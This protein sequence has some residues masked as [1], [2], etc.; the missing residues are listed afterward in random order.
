[1]NILFLIGNGFDLNLDM[2]TKYSDFYKHYKLIQ[3]ESLAI[4]K[5]KDSISNDI[6]NWSDLE[7]ALGEYT[8]NL[9]TEKEFEEVYE[10]IGDRLAEYLE[11]EE[12]DFNFKNIDGKKLHDYFSFPEKSLLTADRNE[13][14]A[15]RNKIEKSQSNVFLITFNYTKTL[16]KLLGYSNKVININ[17]SGA[18]PIVLQKIEHIHGFTNDRMVMGVNDVSQISNKSFHENQNILDALVKVNCNQVQKHTLD[19]WCKS[20]IVKANL[21]CIFGSSIGDTDNMW[22]ELVGEQLK[23]DIKLIIF[24]KGEKIPLRRPYKKAN[25]ERVK[26]NYFLDKTK[27]ND[28]E[29][30]NASGKIFIGINTNMFD[31]RPIK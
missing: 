25:I 12:S 5:L 16:E 15:F 11:K 21:I 10:D 14:S 2:K 29:K 8:K 1:M 31:L 20:Q 19:N 30:K 9:G 3:S 13:I 6:E 7:L 26:K 24:E 22:W 17:S 28:K 18:Y 23:K 4:N 27:L